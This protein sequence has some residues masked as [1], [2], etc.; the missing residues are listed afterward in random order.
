MS[1]LVPRPGQAVI[2]L[3]DAR[4]RVEGIPG[5]TE[6]YFALSGKSEPTSML[7]LESASRTGDRPT[8]PPC[9][10]PS[11]RSRCAVGFTTPPLACA[12]D[13]SVRVTRRVGWDR[14]ARIPDVPARELGTNPPHP[15]PP[16]GARRY[17]R[18]EGSFEARASVGNPTRPR[19]PLRRPPETMRAGLRVERTLETPVP[20]DPGAFALRPSAAGCLGG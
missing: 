9:G 7:P 12:S 4:H 19:G 2:P 17:P 3:A 16:D 20:R 10:F 1:R 8:V 11:D 15:R 14:C 18:P 13:S 5:L 6:L